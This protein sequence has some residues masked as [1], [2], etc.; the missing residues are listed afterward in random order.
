MAFRHIARRERTRAELRTHLRDR[1]V[2]EAL[3]SQTVAALSEQGYL[4]DARFTR[5]FVQDRRELDGWGNERIART[6]RRRGIDDE[7]IDAALAEGDSARTSPDGSVDPHR[8][9]LERALAVLRRRVPEP[10]QG[11]RAAERALGFLLRRG[12]ESDLALRA[13]RLH[14]RGGS[15]DDL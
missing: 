1:G 2:D 15:L 7:L 13:V 3:T 5:L 8:D 12:Y 4:D 10:P 14:A 11:R 9:E 6:L